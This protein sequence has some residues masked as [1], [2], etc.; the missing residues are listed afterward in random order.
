MQPPWRT[1]ASHQR[2]PCLSRWGIPPPR[3]PPWYG[4]ARPCA[5]AERERGGSGA[6]AERLP[7]GTCVAIA[8]PQ[9][10]RAH[11]RHTRHT[12]RANC[13]PAATHPPPILH[14]ALRAVACYTPRESLLHSTPGAAALRAVAR[15]TPR[16]PNCPSLSRGVPPLNRVVT[17]GGNAHERKAPAPSVTAWA[18]PAR[19]GHPGIAQGRACGST[20]RGRALRYAR[21]STTRSS[22]FRYVPQA[23]PLRSAGHSTPSS[24][25]SYV[26]SS[27]VRTANTTFT[28][29]NRR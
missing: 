23:L 4:R 6:A 11:P 18:K 22:T 3:P 27:S 19:A 10:T 5:R 14:A 21:H 2:L 28:T 9:H 29:R 24:S 25:R 26:I 12:P 20:P 17:R 1:H 7:T 16:P 15:S 13:P 8:Q